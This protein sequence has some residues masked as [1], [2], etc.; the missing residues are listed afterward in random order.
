MKFSGSSLVFVNKESFSCNLEDE[1]VI[2]GIKDGIYYGLDSVG[3]FIWDLL[4]E[5]ISVNDI[6]DSIMEKYE[7]DKNTCEAD[8]QIFLKS[9]LD[10][11]LLEVQE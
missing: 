7:V 5:P 9:L 1:V 11:G 2:L 3:S 6:R 10:K 8:L 4:K